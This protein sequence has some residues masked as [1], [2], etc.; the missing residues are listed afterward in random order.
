MHKPSLLTIVVGC[1]LVAMGCQ[2]SDGSGDRDGAPAD[3]AVDAGVLDS[4]IDA[5]AQDAGPPPNFELTTTAFGEGEVIPLR[6]E[7]GGGGMQG[8]GENISP[9]LTWTAGPAGTLSYA[10][11]MDDVDSG[12]V[13]WVIYNIPPKVLQLPENMPSGYSLT[14][15]LGAR[16]AEMQGTGYYGY[17]GPCSGPA[18]NTYRWTIHAMSTATVTGAAQSTTE[19]EMVPLIEADSLESTS[20]SGES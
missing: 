9:D 1:A 14:N 12:V 16:Q 13:H 10:I 20:F 18:T 8:P 15:P 11:I 2:G 17:F 7:C 6:Y 4:G 5:A 3:S 19:Y